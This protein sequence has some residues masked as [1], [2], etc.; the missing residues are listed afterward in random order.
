MD[1]SRLSTAIA[2]AE[3]F[4]LDPKSYRAALRREALAWHK[5]GEPW[6]VSPGSPEQ[7]DMLRVA[8]RMAR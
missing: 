6:L 8:E 7:S 2:V 3:A 5:H 4:G 1:R